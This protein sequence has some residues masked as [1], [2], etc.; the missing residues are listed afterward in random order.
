MTM[1]EIKEFKSKTHEDL[2]YAAFH[3]FSRY[4]YEGTTVRMIADR[5]GVSAGQVTFYF[6]S[7]ENLYSEI[8]EY[9]VSQTN[10]VYDPICDR[11]RALQGSG[12]LD[13]ITAL[14]YLHLIIDLQ[15]EFMGNPEN[16]DFM[17]LNFSERLDTPEG[18]MAIS[19][20]IT[21]KIEKLTA[22]LLIAASGGMMDELKANL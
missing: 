12:K 5:A 3:L 22:E 18:Q 21:G 15:I 14:D 10:R 6:G 2:F 7:K 19:C 20:A 9:I 17:M 16:Y 4:G 8:M 1:V 11:V 13:R